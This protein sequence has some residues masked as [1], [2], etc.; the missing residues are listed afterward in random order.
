[1]AIEDDSM[2]GHRFHRTQRMI[3]DSL[4]DSVESTRSG[5]DV[6]AFRS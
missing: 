6:S 4:N 1:M 2:I 3:L 5:V